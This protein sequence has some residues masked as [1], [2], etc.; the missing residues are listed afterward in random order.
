MRAPKEAGDGKAKITVS[1]PDW[2][3]GKVTPATFEVPVLTAAALRLFE[4]ERLTSRRGRW[5]GWFGLHD[6]PA[7]V[8]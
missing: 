6:S 8:H 3:D 4:V 5:A 2:K 7:I 1:F